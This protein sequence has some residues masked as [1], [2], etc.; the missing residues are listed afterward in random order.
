VLFGDWPG[1]ERYFPAPDERRED[2][3]RF[4]ASRFSASMR[5]DALLAAGGL[6]GYAVWK[7]VSRAKVGLRSAELG[8]EVQ[9]H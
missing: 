8:P 6:D 1:L 5:A 9:V 7:R 4:K 2:I 3:S